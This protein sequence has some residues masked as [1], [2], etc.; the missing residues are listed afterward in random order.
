MTKAAAKQMLLELMTDLSEECFHA[1][2]MDGLEYALW[3]AAQGGKPY[4]YGQCVISTEECRMLKLLSETA[5]GWW[6]WRDDEVFLC[7]DEWLDHLKAGS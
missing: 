5:G 1:G 2:W 6:V 3:S 4:K 7:L